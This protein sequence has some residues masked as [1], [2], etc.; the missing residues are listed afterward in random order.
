MSLFARFP[1]LLAMV[2]CCAVLQAQETTQRINRNNSPGALLTNYHFGVAFP[3]GDWENR[4]GYFNH[5]GAGVE[6]M[7]KAPG[8]YIFGANGSY[9]FGNVVNEDPLRFLRDPEGNIMGAQ[10]VVADIDL[11]QRGWT[12]HLIFGKLWAF[13]P[14][15]QPRNGLRTTLGIGFLSHKIRIQDDPQNFVPG[16]ADDYRKGYDRLSWGLSIQE[17][18]GWQYMSKDR[19][20]NFYLAFEFGQAFT[21]GRRDIQFDTRKPF[22]DKGT[23]LYYGLKFNWTLPFYIGEKGEEIYY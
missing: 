21:Q 7:T 16:I 15:R 20:V 4:F 12:A 2:C 5:A 3:A 10:S 14:A 17:N 22:Y 18:I 8:N 6:Y 1:L 23:D 13:N 19:L 11:K 9:V